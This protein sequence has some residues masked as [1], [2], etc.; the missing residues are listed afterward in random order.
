MDYLTVKDVSVA[1]RHVLVR[2]D[3]NVPLSDDDSVADDSRIKAGLPT[4]EFLREQGAKLILVSHLGR[5]GGREVPDLSLR[6]VVDRLSEL[7]GEDV[8]LLREI[9]GREVRTRLADMEA[10]EVVF[11]ENIRFHPGETENDPRLA[12]QLAGLADIYVNDAFGTA[13]RAHASTHGVAE[14]LPGVIGLLMEEELRVLTGLREGLRSPYC[15]ILGGAKISDKLTVCRRLLNKVDALMLGGGLANTFS[16]CLGY[17]VGNSLVEP[18]MIP[19]VRSIV[20]EANRKDVDLLMPLDVVVARNIAPSAESRVV[21]INDV[22]PNWSIVDIGPRTVARYREKLGEARTVFWNGPM[23]IFEIRDFA[24]GTHQ[25]ARILAGLEDAETVI[26]GGESVEAVTNIGVSDEIDHISTAGGAALA[27]LAGEE[28][29]ALGV[30]QRVERLRIPWV[31]GNWKMHTKMEDAREL[32]GEISARWDRAEPEVV[33]F[34]PHTFVQQAAQEASGSPVAIGGQDCHWEDSGA[35]TGSVSAIML[36]SAG[37]RYTLVGHSE[38]RE[39]LGDYDERVRDKLQAAVDAGLSAVLCVGEQLTDRDRN[40]HRERV[41]EQLQIA[42]GDRPDYPAR[43]LIVAYE[44][45]WAIGTGRP[46]GL[47]DVREMTSVIREELESLLGTATAERIRVVYGGSV[48]ADNVGDF[49]D[50]PDVDGVLVGGA[51][52]R[53]KSFVGICEG[54]REHIVGSGDDG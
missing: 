42:I 26:G 47:Q 5:P 39:Y 43:K 33:L 13:H 23:G 9:T 24:D 28:L 20:A 35:Y 6:P 38:C 53:V 45:V 29:P 7:L 34:P 8:S 18:E 51:S 49:V 1:E 11:L 10:G 19:E 46:A 41:R 14:Y 48:K 52:L 32:A 44:P 36:R 31:G 17:S 4:I 37:A 50:L 16:L 30:L 15:A 54:I 3:F 40:L 2:V 27:F 12:R 21:D 22:D 25:I